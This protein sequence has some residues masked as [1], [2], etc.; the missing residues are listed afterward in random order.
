M[1]KKAGIIIG[2]LFIIAVLFLN[3]MFNGNKEDNTK[4]EGSKPPSAYSV[5][6]NKPVEKPKTPQVPSTP[7]KE[8]VPTEVTQ[9]DTFDSNETT[10]K[11]AFKELEESDL[12]KPVISRTEVMVVSKKKV[13]VLDGDV[14]TS[15][16][17][18]LVYAVDLLTGDETLSLYL[19]GVTFNELR[20]GDKLKVVYNVHKND[21]NVDFPVIMSVDRVE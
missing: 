21:A 16:S 19:N 18:Q 12:G 8:D 14:A 3:W 1:N 17:K 9:V 7:V 20:V 6:E 15:E 10:K 11:T 2:A 5:T 4:A 13:I